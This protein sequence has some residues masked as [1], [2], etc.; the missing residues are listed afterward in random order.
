MPWPDDEWAQFIAV[1]TRGFAARDPFTDAD[2]A[3]YRL[4]LDAVEPAAAL[5]A[6]Q[7]LVLEGQTMRPKP[8]EIV[9]RV[10]RDRGQPTFDEACR[11]MFGR[12]GVLTARPRGGRY[13]DDAEDVPEAERR[14]AEQ[15]R[16]ADERDVIRQAL[17]EVHPLVAAFVER[18]GFDRLRLLE[19]DD[20]D[21]GALRRRELEQAWDR[22]VE[23]FDGRE[24][25]ALAAG[26]DRRG[27]LARL[28]PL[29]ALGRG[30]TPVR[31]A[32]AQPE[33]APAS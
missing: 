14:T 19:L 8:G 27:Q 33:E 18:Q 28:D 30:P 20:P 4:L 16:W 13:V 23:A 31:P 15:K 9:E 21:Y 11:L 7:E 17:A 24:V 26:G 22:H 25:A 29:A 12:G 1:L 3:V 6:V 32:L 10:R 5:R 2:A